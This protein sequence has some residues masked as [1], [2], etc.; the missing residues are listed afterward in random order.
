V[1]GGEFAMRETAFY[2]QVEHIE[3]EWRGGRINLPVF[4]YDVTTIVAGFLTPLDRVLKLLPSPRMKPLRATP[5]HAVTTIVCFEYRDS[6]IGPYNEVA[7]SFPI[8]IDK[9]TT[10]LTGLLRHIKEGPMAYVH[11]LPVTTEPAYHAGV[12]FYNYPKFI[13]NI[14]FK[15]EG[16]RVTCRLAEGDSHI[17]T[18]SV[19]EIPVK[20]LERWRFHGITIRDGRILRSEVILNVGEQ[21]ISRNSGDVKLELGSHPIAEELRSLN[22]GRMIHLQ[23]IPRNQSI[24]TPVLESYTI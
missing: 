4:Y 21:G 11:H 8:T 23:Y 17:L 19:R 3:T 24:L 15:R 14:D 9:P 12:D 7:I 6:D 20:P 16:G 10:V 1:K 2:E 13:A 5:W 22:L 18:L